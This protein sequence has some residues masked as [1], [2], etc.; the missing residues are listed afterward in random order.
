MT[1]DKRVTVPRSLASSTR[2]ISVMS[3]RGDRMIILHSIRTRV[4]HASL[5]NT[6]TMLT[7][8]N[9]LTSYDFFLQ[10]QRQTHTRITGLHG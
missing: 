1:E 6:L 9:T 2:I 5:W 3:W 8:D 10:L 7:D 4:D